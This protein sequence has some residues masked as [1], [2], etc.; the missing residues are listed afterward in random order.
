MTDTE[1]QAL[2]QIKN[3]VHILENRISDHTENLY[4]ALEKITALAKIIALAQDAYKPDTSP[5]VVPYRFKD[6]RSGKWVTA[7]ITHDQFRNL[8]EP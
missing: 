6:E 7:M 5:F 1:Q 2:I 8:N 4:S 3:I